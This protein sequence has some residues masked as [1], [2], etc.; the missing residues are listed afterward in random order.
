MEPISLYIH[1]PF[2]RQKCAYCDF[3]SYPKMD[4]HMDAYCQSLVAQMA[5]LSKQ[6]GKP[7]AAT[8]FIGGGTP[9]LLPPH[10]MDMVLTAAA[11]YFP[12]IPNWEATCECNPGTITAEFLHVLKRHNVNRL[13]MG[14]QAYQEPLLKTLGRIHTWSDVVSTF[15]LAR[16]TGFQNISLDLMFGLP[17][18]TLAD[19]IETLSAALALHPPH[20]SCYGLILEEGTPFYRLANE[21]RISF[22]PE[23][24]ERQMYDYTLH[25]LDNAGMPPYE[26]SNFAIPGQECRHNIAYWTQAFYL[27]VGAAAHSMMPCPANAAYHRFGA[28]PNIE[29]YM[30]GIQHN[31]PILCEDTLISPADAR[32]ETLMLGLRMTSGV[33]AQ[34]FA[35]RHGQSL[36]SAFGTKIAPLVQ[37]GLLT[38]HGDRLQLTRHGM[39]VQ[40]AVLVDLMD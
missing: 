22:P 28:T 38:W 27:G 30:D 25:T 2:C 19:W 4:A 14:A 20:I 11:K 24:I 15:T 29:T 21:G 12:P 39:D 5:Q 37:K 40:N 26:I 34:D 23:D 35:R 32:F 33:S 31:K 1:I 7:S 16:Q 9:S 8:L 18:Q 6:Y 13:S 17:D 10:L 3:A 36:D